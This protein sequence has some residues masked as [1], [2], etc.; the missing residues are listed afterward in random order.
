[1]EKRKISDKNRSWLYG[2]VTHW[3]SAGIISAE[4][5]EQI[6][7]V[8]ESEQVTHEEKNSRAM[9]V[10]RAMASFLF[11]LAVLLLIGN[12]WEG[13][14][15][16]IKLFIVLGAVLG[17]HA[18]GIWLRYK[19]QR[20]MASQ[21]V[22][23]FACLLYGAGI[24]LIAQIYHI[25]AHYPDG[26]WWWAIGVFPFAVL[27]DSTLLHVLLLGLLAIWSG[28]ELI[29][30]K[31]FFSGS[32]GIVF[33]AMSFPLMILPSYV[34][35]YYKKSVGQVNLCLV[36]SLWWFGLQMSTMLEN[37]EFL[38]AALVCLAALLI[39]ISSFHNPICKL[40][41]PYSFWGIVYAA[42]FLI[43]KSSPYI[44]KRSCGWSVWFFAAVI[45][46][47]L[48]LYVAKSCRVEGGVRE[49]LTAYIQKQGLWLGLVFCLVLL[50]ALSCQ[51]WEADTVLFPV[52][53]AN[54]SML[55]LSLAIVRTGIREE[56][57]RLFTFGVLYFLLWAII[58]YVDLFADFGGMLGAAGMFAL[59]GFILFAVAKYWGSLKGRGHVQENI[60]AGE[61]SWPLLDSVI[62]KVINKENRVFVLSVVLQILVLVGMLALNA[63]PLLIG[64]TILLRVR[65]VDPRDM[66]RGDYIILDY[67]LPRGYDHETGKL[68]VTIIPDTDGRH[69][70]IADV[71][72]ETPTNGKYIR[73]RYDGNY[74]QLI[75]MGIEAFYVQEGQ[76]KYWEDN[77]RSKK[78]SAEIALSPWGQ[79]KLKRLVLDE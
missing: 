40:G 39:M 62:S 29:S 51:R 16:E 48:I 18:I 11:G 70:R 15:R 42:G 37:L 57:G 23:F 24:W 20:I 66:F 67:D 14:A 26:V 43:A 6:K 56:R 1:M 58:R 71:A 32:D 38:F 53:V 64:E 72:N 76:G 5:G 44:S 45:I 34:R 25:S 2:E 35:A 61:R 13:L 74:R 30:V 63:L 22:T 54:V 78:V 21:L 28:M 55:L 41:R 10:I 7:A 50:A 65:P 36:V 8:Y 69:Y 46:L 31:S 59:C 19:R 27:L 12:N 47:S 60:N 68:F 33:T 9:F 52:I 75:K 73:A 17:T 49:N 79:A 77:I 3:L 4:S